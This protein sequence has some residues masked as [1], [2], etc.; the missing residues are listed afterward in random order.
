MNGHCCLLSF[1]P[2][3]KIHNIPNPKSQ[4]PNCLRAYFNVMRT[5]KLCKKQPYTVKI[6]QRN[7]ATILQTQLK[8][9]NSRARK[10]YSV[11]VQWTFRNGKWQIRSDDIQECVMSDILQK[12]IDVGR[13]K[14][15]RKTV[16]SEILFTSGL[17]TT[18]LVLQVIQPCMIKC[19]ENEVKRFQKIAITQFQ[20]I[21]WR[22]SRQAESSYKSLSLNA[23]IV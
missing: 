2:L 7:Y 14:R 15:Q 9:V 12:R 5:S 10:F 22:I 4:K 16:R 21:Y 3:L 13:L 19:S 11:R 8:I 23:D 6:C 1:A 17:L 20:V 18:R